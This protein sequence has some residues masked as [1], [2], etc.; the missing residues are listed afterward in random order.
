[1]NKKDVKRI[2]KVLDDHRDS[3]SPMTVRVNF[4][5]SMIKLSEQS[6]ELD[7]QKKEIDRILKRKSV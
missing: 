1:M 2:I 7:G 5:Y 3:G 6:A 4:L